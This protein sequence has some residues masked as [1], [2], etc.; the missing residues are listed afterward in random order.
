MVSLEQAGGQTRV[1]LREHDERVYREL[2]VARAAA[3]AARLTMSNGAL[4]VD[5]LR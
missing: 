5:V 1:L 4:L 3:T 2:V